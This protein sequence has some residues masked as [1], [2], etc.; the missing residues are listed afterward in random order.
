MNPIFLSNNSFLK[1][2]KLLKLLEPLLFVIRVNYIFVLTLKLHVSQL[3]DV[4]LVLKNIVYW[5]NADKLI[6]NVKMS[7]MIIFHLKNNTHEEAQM[8]RNINN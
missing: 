7:K 4:T 5:L 8:K 1:L 2:F 6:L 3:T